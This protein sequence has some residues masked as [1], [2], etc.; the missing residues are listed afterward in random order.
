MNAK[1][2]KHVEALMEFCELHDINPHNLDKLAN[3]AKRA[4]VAAHDLPQYRN[5]GLT[6]AQDLHFLYAQAW[7]MLENGEIEGE[8]LDSVFKRI[9]E[10]TNDGDD[11]E[12]TWLDMERRKLRLLK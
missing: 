3:H 9:H 12:V 2:W 6:V 4:L 8:E 5:C 10:L 1:D 7:K 11:R